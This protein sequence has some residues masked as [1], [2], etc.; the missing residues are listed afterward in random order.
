M[1]ASFKWL[2]IPG[3]RGNER[4]PSYWLAHMMRAIH[5]T[6]ST[7]SVRSL[8]AGL[9]ERSSTDLE[10]RRFSSFAITS[11]SLVFTTMRSPRRTA[12]VGETRIIVPSR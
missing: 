11:P 3:L 7:D 8:C 12:D 1:F 2:W 4:Q 9:S 10:V 5:S 6:S